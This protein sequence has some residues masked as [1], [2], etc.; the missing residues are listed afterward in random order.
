MET[1]NKL[2]GF[3]WLST[4]ASEENTWRLKPYRNI[5]KRSLDLI[6]AILILPFL[7]PII[8]VLAIMIR[9]DSKGPAFYRSRRMGKKGKLFDCL[10][11]RTMY[12]D[13]DQKLANLLESDSKLKKE[14][15]IYR[16][17]KKD[18][19]ITKV[20]KLL[21]SFSLDELPQI[22]NVIRGEMSFIGPRPAFEEEIKNYYGL[23]QKEYK[24]VTPGITG[25]WQISG[26]NNTTFEKR[27]LLDSFYSKNL[28]IMLDLKIMLKTIP[29]VFLRKGAY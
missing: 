20:G 16:K 7:L 1:P 3:R 24:A 17:L 29:A 14:Y 23:N 22:F 6:F 26:R 18:P 13:A 21:R 8:I 9:L 4:T 19:R 11:L 5:F 28:S 2:Q 10:K 25:L 12:V 15:E 27:V